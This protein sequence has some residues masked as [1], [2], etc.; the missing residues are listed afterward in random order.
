MFSTIIDFTERTVEH[1]HGFRHSDFV[2]LFSTFDGEGF[3]VGIEFCFVNTK[4]G[5]AIEN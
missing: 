2:Y 5:Y 1:F 4:I 3:N